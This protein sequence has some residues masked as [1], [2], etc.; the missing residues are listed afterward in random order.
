[1]LGLAG[2][3]QFIPR[4]HRTQLWMSSHVVQSPRFLDSFDMALTRA[5][6]IPSTPENGLKLSDAAHN[7]CDSLRSAAPP[8]ASLVA[9]T[10][11]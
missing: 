11:F 3:V 5:N 7:P 8:Q 4:S 9:A 1:M 2:A 6:S 10:S